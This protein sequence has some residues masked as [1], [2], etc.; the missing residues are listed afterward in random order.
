MLS[1]SEID[2]LSNIGSNPKKSMSL[3]EVAERLEWSDTY[4]S[5]VVSGLEK[6]DFVRAERNGGK[7][8]ISV[9]E[10]PPV[11]QLTD[12]TSEYSHVNFPDLISGSALKILYY[13]D[14][15]RT[16]AELAER[17]NLSRDTVYR[18]LKSLQRVGIVGKSG[19]EYRLTEPF[20]QLSD[21]S[22][23]VAH[24]EHRQEA[25]T[26]TTGVNIRWET[27]EEY[28]FSCDG[29]VYSE[30][31]YKTGPAIFEDFGVT[32]LTRERD[33]YFR[34]EKISKI[35]PP[36]LV[37]QTMLIDDST[38][39][40][41]YSLLLMRKQNINKSDLKERAEQYDREA[42]IDLVTIITEL[43]SYLETKGEVTSNQLPDWEDF[44]RTAAEYSISV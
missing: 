37:I 30:P 9:A 17:S 38:R 14:N 43:V 31:F 24:H 27:H 11:E 25:L 7:K 39:Y 4:A 41:T 3:H 26:H 2:L 19:S 29:A 36:E 1:K 15:G 23:A 42:T 18:R 13:L 6:R 22:R 10:I 5:R 35:T 33:H 12:L 16:A 32:L 8:L 40:R 44:K 34:S 21:F 28:L 20:S